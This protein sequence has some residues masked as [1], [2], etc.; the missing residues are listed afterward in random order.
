VLALCL[1]GEA[2]AQRLTATD[3]LRAVATVWAEARY[4]FAWWD[5]VRADWDSAFTATLG[6]AAARQTDLQFLRRLRRMLAL[7]G[8][9]QAAV[10]APSLRERWARPPLAIRSVDGRPLIFD[11]VESDEMRIVR[12]ERLAEITAVQ[13]VPAEHWV[14]DSVLPETPGAT[15]DHRWRRAVAA[16]LDGE[17]G[18]ALHLEIRLADGTVRGA[19]VTRSLA[20]SER[21]PLGPPPL[22]VV[23]LPDSAVHVR[24]NSFADPDVVAAFDRALPRFT[25]V[26]ALVLDVRDNDAGDSETGYQIL[27]RLVDHPFLTVARRTPEYRPVQWPALDEPAPGWSLAAPDTVRPRRDRPRFTGPVALLVSGRTLGAAEDVA[28]A[29]RAARRGP[30]V[31]EA[32]AGAAGRRLALPLAAD[33]VFTLTVTR[34]SLPDGTEFVGTGLEPDVE[35]GESV[36]DLQ[37]GRDAALERARELLRR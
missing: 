28:A 34:H 18:T 31:G 37:A 14:R 7:L 16:M 17:R 8:D 3:R 35:V 6:Q 9:P 15:A 32:T 1:A 27:A 23:W 19:S 26:R 30:L 12:P 20:Q 21:S 22:E 13:G 4:N 11:Y 2:A 33:W 5:Q 29:F 24:L 36:R 10:T 25:G